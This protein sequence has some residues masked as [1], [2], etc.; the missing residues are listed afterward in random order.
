MDGKDVYVEE[1]RL[2]LFLSQESPSEHSLPITHFA[3]EKDESAQLGIIDK[4][5][6]SNHVF[7]LH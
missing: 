2:T 4:F 6:Y 5:Q 7:A 1:N 3:L